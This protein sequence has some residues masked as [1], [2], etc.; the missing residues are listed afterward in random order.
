MD[1]IPLVCLSLLQ[2]SE[3]I[4]R[5]FGLEQKVGHGGSSCVAAFNLAQTGPRRCPNQ[6]MP[7][8][9]PARLEP[10]PIHPSTLAMLENNAPGPQKIPYVETALDFCAVV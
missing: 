2:V 8:P 4:R 5:R 1:A 7:R 9:E 3:G 10:Q 6:A